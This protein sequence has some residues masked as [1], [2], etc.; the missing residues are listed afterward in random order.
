MYDSLG[1]EDR[2]AIRARID[3]MVNPP[4]F[5][6]ILLYAPNA[7][8]ASYQAVI[9]SIQEQIYPFWKLW[10]PPWMVAGDDPRVL[11]APLEAEQ[12]IEPAAFFNAALRSA[13]GEFVIPISH[14]FRLA[15]QALYEVAAVLSSDSDIELLYTDEDRVDAKGQ[16]CLPRFKTAWDPDLMLGRDAVANLAIYQRA[17]LTR[18]GGMRLGLSSCDLT[19]Y[20]LA[21]RAGSA[22]GAVR[23]RHLPAILCHRSGASEAALVSDA[24]GARA[25]VRAHL[26]AQGESGI[27][28]V[29]APLAPGWTRIVRPPPEPAPL[30]SI[31]VPTRDRADLLARCTDGVLYRTSYAPLELLIVDNGSREPDTLALLERLAKDSRVHILSRPGPFNYSAL[32]N[33]AARESHGDILLLLN[34]DVDV[35]TPGWLAEMVAHAI[36][37]EIGAVGAKLLYAD[38]RVQHAGVVLGPGWAVSHQLRL[39]DRLDPGPGG[40][41][42][43]TRTVSAV[44]G[45]C[46]ALRKPVF[47]EVGG[48]NESD[49]KVA[50]NDIDLCLRLGDHGYRNVW[51]PYAELFHLESA[52]RGYGNDTPENRAR[53]TAES[54]YFRRTWASLLAADPYH[55][56]NVAYGWEQTSLSAPPRRERPWMASRFPST[57]DTY[58]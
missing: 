5:S 9:A 53:N 8:L 34:N 10:V 22:A 55:N 24:A 43:L 15:E 6:L 37:P 13:G 38:G 26:I 11:G 49:L 47:F 44:T 45:A 46:L 16:R 19:R 1:K 7:S 42:A 41:L 57:K 51:T 29:P 17:S 39:S 52:S 56:P 25:M 30:V 20:E 40:E 3:A 27:D 4:T 54:T 48:L 35:I 12:P 32:N 50:L 23:V 28:I 36:R 18:L 58:S 14:D 2:G 33:D 21:L 31:I